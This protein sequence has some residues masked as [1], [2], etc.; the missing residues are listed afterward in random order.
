MMSSKKGKSVSAH[1]SHSIKTSFHLYVTTNS[2]LN[3]TLSVFF[4]LIKIM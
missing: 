3:Y 1:K 4:F 2:A